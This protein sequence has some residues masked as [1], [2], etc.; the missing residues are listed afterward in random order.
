[1]RTSNAMPN[2]NRLLTAEEFADLDLEDGYR[3]ELVDGRVERVSPAKWRHGQMATRILFALEAH[4][5]ANRSGET[6]LPTGFTLARLPDT[7][8]E[9]DVAFIRRE[10]LPA[11]GLPDAFWQ[12]APDLVV[13]VLSSSDRR[14][15]I[16]RKLDDYL[17]HGV[18]LA[19]VVDPKKQTVTAYRPLTPAV[20]N[21]LDDTL[22]AEDLLPGFRLPVRTIFG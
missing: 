9:P 2:A 19:W 20:V 21:G 12:G 1:M 6:V 15:R 13:E 8:R 3:Y 4:G 7:V 11:E 17:S 5:R 10:R 16:Q 22:D 14:G 18:T